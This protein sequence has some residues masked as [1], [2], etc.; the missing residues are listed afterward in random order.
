MAVPHCCQYRSQWPDEP[1]YGLRAANEIEKVM[2]REGRRVWRADT[3]TQENTFCVQ[4]ILREGP[5]E[6]GALILEAITAG[7]GVIPPPRG[8]MERVQALCHQYNLLL[9]ID[10]VVMGLGRY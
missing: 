9:I 4:V 8:Y 10:E 7:G 6:C 3:L 5:N 1:N 2:L